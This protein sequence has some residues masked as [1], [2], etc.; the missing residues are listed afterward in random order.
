MSIRTG[1]YR[2]C[3]IGVCKSSQDFTDWFMNTDSANWKLLEEKPVSVQ[4][5]IE[6]YKK[7]EIDYISDYALTQAI[8][9]KIGY[10]LN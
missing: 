8:S 2:R 1:I 10:D 9:E 3:F 4:D 7:C 5:C 6:L